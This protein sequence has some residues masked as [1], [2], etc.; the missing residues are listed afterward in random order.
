MSANG[1]K[2]NASYVGP[3]W[4][5]KLQFVSSVDN[6]VSHAHTNRLLNRLPEAI[7]QNYSYPPSIYVVQGFKNRIT[8]VEPRNLTDVLTR[9]TLGQN[10]ILFS[11]KHVNLQEAVH[12]LLSRE[13]DK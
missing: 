3:P 5:L 12:K 6:P 8:I 9:A 13:P 2:F 11:E 7:L 4:L 10:S 1:L